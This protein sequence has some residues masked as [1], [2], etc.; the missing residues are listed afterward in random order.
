MYLLPLPQAI[1]NLLPASRSLLS[2]QKM[3]QINF[4]LLM[5]VRLQ[6][7][8]KTGD[9]AFQVWKASEARTETWRDRQREVERL[10]DREV[11][12]QA[13]KS[14][15]R[16]TWRETKQDRTRRHTQ[17]SLEPQPRLHAQQVPHLVHLHRYPLPRYSHARKGSLSLWDE[18]WVLQQGG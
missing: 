16:K 2:P 15:K 1:P 5:G 8:G 3:F 14:G 4:L 17:L 10:R 12:R 6:A 18:L 13:E 9:R 7:D 11:E